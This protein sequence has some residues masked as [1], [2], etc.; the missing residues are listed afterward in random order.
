MTKNQKT[1]RTQIKDLSV[2]EKKM[3]K[4]EMERLKGGAQS[5][6]GLDIIVK[7]PQIC[8]IHKV[9]LATCPCSKQQ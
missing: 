5:K 4:E 6:P 2:S 8:S 1:K 9:Y 3:T 7:V